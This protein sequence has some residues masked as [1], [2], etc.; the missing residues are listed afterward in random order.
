MRSIAS[1]RCMPRASSRIVLRST[2]AA[3]ALPSALAP[4][5]NIDRSGSKSGSSFALS[6]C[7]YQSRSDSDGLSIASRCNAAEC[8]AR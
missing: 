3:A 1:T 5:R 6:T 8:C 2:E 4:V 7:R